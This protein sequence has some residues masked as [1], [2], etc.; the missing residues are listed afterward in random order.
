MAMGSMHYFTYQRA[1]D[2]A[3]K[4]MPVGRAELEKQIN[5]IKYI[6][7]S[8][9]EGV[10]ISRA[11]HKDKG[12]NLG[13]VGSYIYW[14]AEMIGVA[15]VAWVLMRK[16]AA[17]PFCV[18]CNTWKHDRPL[19]MVTVPAENMAVQAVKDGDVV[20]LLQCAGPVATEGLLLKTAVCPRCGADGEVDVALD[21]LTKNSKGQKQTTTVTRV[22]YPGEVLRFLPGGGAG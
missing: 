19:A 9:E 6:D 13:Y 1:L 3:A 18:G 16:A 10:T 22:T 17:A 12:M 20:Q 11:A 8:A 7:L 4:T 14:L 21:R 15:A 5:F 2:A